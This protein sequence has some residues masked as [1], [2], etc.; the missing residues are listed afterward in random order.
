MWREYG[1]KGKKPISVENVK[2]RK[3]FRNLC[4]N[5]KIIW[6]IVKIPEQLATAD[7][8]QQ[9]LEQS[10]K[11]DNNQQPE[12]FSTIGKTQATPSRKSLLHLLNLL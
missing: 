12:L 9:V 7:N 3:V 8:A 6:E 10:T 2:E 11:K 4:I 5:I 1:K